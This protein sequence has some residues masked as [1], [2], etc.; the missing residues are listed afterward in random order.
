MCGPTVERPGI[1]IGYEIRQDDPEK[2]DCRQAISFPS[3]GPF[4]FAIPPQLKTQ[5]QHSE[6]AGGDSLIARSTGVSSLKNPS[7]R[8]LSGPAASC[9]AMSVRTSFR[10]SLVLEVAPSPHFCP[11]SKRSRSIKNRV[12]TRSCGAQASGNL[13]LPLGR[14]KPMPCAQEMSVTNILKLPRMKLDGGSMN[15]RGPDF[16][17]TWKRYSNHTSRRVDDRPACKQFGSAGLTRRGAV[18]ELYAFIIETEQAR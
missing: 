2:S 14:W 8:S 5:Q 1:E 15:W 9:R 17:R 13:Y 3:A 7:Y 18:G 12:P 6:V 11:D 10:R 4:P 16:D